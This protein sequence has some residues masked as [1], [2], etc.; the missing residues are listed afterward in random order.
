MLA[1]RLRTFTHKSTPITLRTRNNVLTGNLVCVIEEFRYRLTKLYS[2]PDQLDGHLSLPV[3]TEAHMT[4]MDR[5][6]FQ[7]FSKVLKT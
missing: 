7:K 1:N 2:A 4:L 3:L 6:K 5:D